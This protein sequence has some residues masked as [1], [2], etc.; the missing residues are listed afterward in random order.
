M[1]LLRGV[2]LILLLSLVPREGLD[3]DETFSPVVRSE[4]VCTV[5]AL[6]SMN[7]LTLHPTSDGHS[8]CLYLEEEV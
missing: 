6:S 4:S 2:K 1:G 5:T 3:N 7:G 8:H